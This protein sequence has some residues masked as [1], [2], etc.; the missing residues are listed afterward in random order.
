MKVKSN[1]ATSIKDMAGVI[2]YIMNAIFF[3]IRLGIFFIT[4]HKKY[5]I[6]TL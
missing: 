3:S 4:Y 1:A 2:T 5:V 6:M